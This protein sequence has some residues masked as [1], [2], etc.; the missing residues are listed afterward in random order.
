MHS[1]YQKLHTHTKYVT[2]IHA[3]LRMSTKL[4][5]SDVLEATHM[6]AM[7]TYFCCFERCFPYAFD[8]KFGERHLPEQFAWRVE[9]K[10]LNI[11]F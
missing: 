8:W 4:S 9:M 3:F 5:R 10:R 1:V 2:T 7:R 11:L 6:Y